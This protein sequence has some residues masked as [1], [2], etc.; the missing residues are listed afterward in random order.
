MTTPRRA[1][2]V[3]PGKIALVALYLAGWAALSVLH[4]HPSDLEW[5]YLPAAQVALAG[6]PLHIYTI[7]LRHGYPLANGPVS[8]AVLAP[9][10]ALA[11]A[12]GWAHSMTLTRLLVMAAFSL[13]PLL[14]AREA[15]HAI[16]RVAPQPLRG[17]RRL[18]VYEVF[19]L[20]LQLWQSMIYYGH[21]EQPLM[22]WLVHLGIRLLREDRPLRASA[23]LG[24]ALLTRT[25]ALVVVIP[26]VLLVLR[27]REWR[28][29]VML[30]GAIGGVVVCG[31]LPF[32][33]ADAPDV[34]YSLVRFHSTEPLVG[35]NV[36]TLLGQTPLA[37]AAR[38]SD[39]LVIL[40]ATVALSSVILLRRP[41]MA[42]G[43]REMYGLLAVCSLCHPLFV[44]MLWPYYLLEAYTFVALWWLLGI[45]SLA[46]VS[47]RVQWWLAGLL[48]L[49]VMLV[50][51]ARQHSLALEQA[52]ITT[53][54]TSVTSAGWNVGPALLLVAIAATLVWPLLVNRRD[55]RQEQ[56]SEDESV[57]QV[58]ASDAR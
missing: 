53:P 49:G 24:L 3:Q 48:P 50:A 25:T 35:G 33:L 14:A 11:G 45:G 18:L 34:L 39:G 4:P 36:W 21:I 9:V 17:P 54:D 26:V 23:V 55:L 13:F 16:D 1:A 46:D 38:G 15:V 57:R 2:L 28:T 29:V 44:N 47:R 32:L 30:C 43:S 41:A 51:Q 31:L 6:H 10:V 40:L 19:L 52:S 22:L 37:L 58:L 27:R 8:I 20:S 56:Q 12:L 42:V 7:G 5:I